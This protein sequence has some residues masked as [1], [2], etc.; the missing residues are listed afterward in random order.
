MRALGVRPP[1]LYPCDRDDWEWHH[2]AGALIHTIIGGAVLVGVLLGPL[3]MGLSAAVGGGLLA[4]AP[5][6]LVQLVLWVSI[7]MV[8]AL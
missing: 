4:A 1:R 8:T 5:H 6:L 3:A 7:G 2:Y